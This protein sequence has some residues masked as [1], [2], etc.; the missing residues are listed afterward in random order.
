MVYTM[1]EN[2]MQSNSM[3][4]LEGKVLDRVVTWKTAFEQTHE[5][6]EVVS[7]EG[8]WGESGPSIGIVSA[9]VL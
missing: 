8:L 5:G 9:K 2:S 6:S 4:G 1:G 7:Q 3:L